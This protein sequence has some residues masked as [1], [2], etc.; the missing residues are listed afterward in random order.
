MNTKMPKINKDKVRKRAALIQKIKQKN[1]GTGAGGANTNIN[2]EKLEKR[3]RNFMSTEFIRVGKPIFAGKVSKKTGCQTIIE[4]VK[5]ND[6]FYIR[7]FECGFERWEDKILNKGKKGVD[8]L[9]GSVRPDD[10]FINEKDKIINWIECK[11]QNGP[12][13]VAEKLQTGTK[14][15]RN[16]KRR[17]PG[18]TINYNYILDAYFRKKAK[19][20]ILDL[21]EDGIPYIWNDDPAFEKKLLN[22]IR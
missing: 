13:S 19:A 3:V 5:K 8:K 15:I 2:G 1:K 4:K 17:F 18:W 16:L 12:G 11:S 14:K 6:Q 7:A 21:G 10:C 20:E 22:I 9:K